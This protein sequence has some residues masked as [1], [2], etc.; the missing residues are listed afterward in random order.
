[1]NACKPPVFGTGCEPLGGL[2]DAADRVLRRQVSPGSPLC[3]ADLVAR[4]PVARGDRV[5][6]AVARG[7]VTLVASA[8]AE[9]NGNAG[10]VIRVRNPATRDVYFARVTGP[11]QVRVDE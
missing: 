1:M 5:S 4:P 2:A 7:P 9:E 10:A 6:V 3:E 8:Q 11:R